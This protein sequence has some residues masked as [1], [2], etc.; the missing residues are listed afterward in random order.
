MC[1]YSCSYPSCLQCFIFKITLNTAKTSIYRHPMTSVPFRSSYCTLVH[2]LIISW[3]TYV[4][5]RNSLL[6]GRFAQWHHHCV[7]LYFTCFTVCFEYYLCWYTQRRTNPAIPQSFYFMVFSFTKL[8]LP[9]FHFL[10][11]L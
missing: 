9:P 10:S 7:V 1:Y 2:V 4:K 6:Y 5:Y 11:I 8:S 3:Y